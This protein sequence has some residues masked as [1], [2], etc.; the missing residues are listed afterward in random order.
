M[1]EGA[2]YLHDWAIN[3]AFFREIHNE[4]G[5]GETG[6][7]D[8]IFREAFQNLGAIIMGRNMFGGGPGLWPSEPWNGWW[9][10]NPP[11]HTDVFVLTHHSREP[12]PMQGGTT[13]HFVTDGI[14]SAHHQARDSAAGKDVVIGGGAN[15]V[16]QYLAAGL[17]DEMDLH[18]APVLL[19]AG[20]R[21]F[22]NVG[23]GVRLESLRTVE[24]PGATHI[25]YRIIKA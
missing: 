5:G 3:T 25:K 13:F 21:L 23:K 16:Q 2:D 12:L 15:T 6:I 24:G 19:G 10:D 14:E 22:D 8:N 17:I 9:G 11:F 18:V 1:G 20:E 7:N 4:Q